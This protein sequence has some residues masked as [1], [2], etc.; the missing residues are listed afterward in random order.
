MAN[1]VL[2]LLMLTRLVRSRVLHRVLP[3]LSLLHV[4]PPRVLP[5]VLLGAKPLVIYRALKL[6]NAGTGRRALEGLPAP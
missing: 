1:R 3:S 5:R 2:S 6:V 4:V